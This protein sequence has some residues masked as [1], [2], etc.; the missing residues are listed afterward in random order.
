MQTYDIFSFKVKMEESN[1]KEEV[2]QDLIHESEEN[3]H[4]LEA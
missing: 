3:Y 1:Q 4:S 2:L